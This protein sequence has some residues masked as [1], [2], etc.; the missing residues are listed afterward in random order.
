MVRLNTIHDIIY[1]PL[2]PM[3]RDNLQK[4]DDYW[5]EKTLAREKRPLAYKSLFFSARL[6]CYQ[7]LID[8]DVDHFVERTGRL[9]EDTKS[10]NM[11]LLK[12]KDTRETVEGFA[13]AAIR[14]QK[15]T[16]IVKDDIVGTDA[17]LF[18][19][20][21][22]KETYIIMDYIVVALARC[23]F[24]IQTICGKALPDDRR[25]DLPTFCTSMLG[26]QR[27]SLLADIK[28]KEL[29]GDTKTVAEIKKS[30]TAK[31][32]KDDTTPYTFNYKYEGV[33]RAMRLNAV[34][35]TL[36]SEGWIDAET[37]PNNF[38]NF[39][40]GKPL[41]CN[42]KWT[43]TA[44]ALC[45]LLNNLTVQPFIEMQKGC[46]KA[47]IAKNQFGKTFDYRGTTD[48]D[49]A[50]TVNTCIDLLNPKFK[51][52]NRNAPTDDDDNDDPFVKAQLREAGFEARKRGHWAK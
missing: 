24:S 46:T 31:R 38:F 6:R 42:I 52:P 28:E 1:G 4:P 29:T 14:E 25:L 15:M 36:V 43:G 7:S 27:L 20:Q 35:Q 47:L 41:H 51:L 3:R 26:R 5:K 45:A 12:M 39:F 22:D 44:A 30:P 2:C 17:D 13:K 21:A 16:G 40:E 50:K 19:R 9:L 48:E 34:M 49:K 8:S 10:P 23:Y 37:T 18:D 11:A 33:E 32:I